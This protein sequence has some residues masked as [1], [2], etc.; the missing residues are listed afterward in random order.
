MIYKQTK[1]SNCAPVAF[2]NLFS[3]YI[4]DVSLENINFLLKSNRHGTDDK[5]IESFLAVCSILFKTPFKKRKTL[6]EGFING[7]L[8]Y[9]DDSGDVHIA[10]AEA[11]GSNTVF[12]YNSL[13][14]HNRLEFT[15]S[16]VKSL[17]RRSKEHSYVR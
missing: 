7:L 11:S 4:L 14:D 3:T 12:I 8:C 16:E 10:Y 5:H 1:S 13:I 17:L 6:P 9:L 15:I 2:Y